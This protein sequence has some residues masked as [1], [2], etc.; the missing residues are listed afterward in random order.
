MSVPLT[1]AS[2]ISVF[3]FKKCTQIVAKFVIAGNHRS[4]LLL[5]L[6]NIQMQH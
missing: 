6:L 1:G 5:Y 3:F 4:D 2:C